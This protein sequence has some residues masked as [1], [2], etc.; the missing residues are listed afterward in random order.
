MLK[1]S[2]KK[3]T[4]VQSKIQSGGKNGVQEINFWGQDQV[5]PSSYKIQLGYIEI[6]KT[7]KFKEK[8]LDTPYRFKTLYDA[9]NEADRIFQGYKYRIVGSND[10]PYWDAPSYL[11]YKRNLSSDIKNQPWYDIIGVE[12]LNE[13]P[14]AKYSPIGKPPKLSP[15]QQYAISEL[16]KLRI[17][18]EAE[19]LKL[20]ETQNKVNK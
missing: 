7:I 6:P 14:Y 13:N 19:R 8:W 15:E 2:K 10:S 18:I 11:H 4:N 16:S 20:L 9:N 3:K 12:V 1:Q 5:P 17:P